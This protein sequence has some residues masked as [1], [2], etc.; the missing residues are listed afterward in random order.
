MLVGKV[1]YISS[2]LRRENLGD[3]NTV[4]TQPGQGS[5][6]IAIKWETALFLFLFDSYRFVLGIL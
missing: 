6:A 2:H 1:T 5:A 3:R 4:S